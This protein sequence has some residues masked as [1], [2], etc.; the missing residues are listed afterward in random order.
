MEEFGFYA[1][2]GLLTLASRYLFPR[3]WE[4]GLSLS[5]AWLSERD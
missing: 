5:H 3:A 2:I 1:L 4:L